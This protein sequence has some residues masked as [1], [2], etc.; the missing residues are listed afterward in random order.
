MIATPASKSYTDVN[1]GDNSHTGEY[2]AAIIKEV[3]IAVGGM[4]DYTD[5]TSRG[6]S[7]V[8]TDNA[9]AI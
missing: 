7:A 1:T 8:V 4:V 9:S 6:I 2:M 3:I 5:F